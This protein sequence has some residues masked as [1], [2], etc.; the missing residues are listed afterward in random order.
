MT[1]SWAECWTMEEADAMLSAG[2]R[3]AVFEDVLIRSLESSSRRLGLV[4]EVESLRE[5]LLSR[6]QR[7]IDD[8]NPILSLLLCFVYELIGCLVVG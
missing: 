4:F 5:S 6:M 1:G 2:A 3:D 7:A 8:M